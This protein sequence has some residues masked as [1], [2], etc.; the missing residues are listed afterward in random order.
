VAVAAVLVGQRPQVLHR[1][2]LRVPVL[3]VLKKKI[4]KG[5][6]MGNEGEKGKKMGN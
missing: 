2:L 3:S 6:E 4:K 1:H 5:R